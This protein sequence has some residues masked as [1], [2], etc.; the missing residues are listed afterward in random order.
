[1]ETKEM[2][3]EQL[4]EVLINNYIDTIQC[5]NEQGDQSILY[6]YLDNGFKGFSNYTNDELIQEY[7]ELYQTD[8]KIIE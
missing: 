5:D 4:I 7:T 2:T 6:S 1:M 3:R 8:I